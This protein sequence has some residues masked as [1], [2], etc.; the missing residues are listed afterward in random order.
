M[1]P[2]T[3]LR[4]SPPL[5]ML[6]MIGGGWIVLRGTWLLGGGAAAAQFLFPTVS[7]PIGPVPAMQPDYQLSPLF[8]LPRDTMSAPMSRPSARR[9]AA[10]SYA[11]AAHPAGGP[12]AQWAGQ[13]PPVVLA[14]GGGIDQLRRERLLR[15]YLT[16][17]GGRLGLYPLPTHSLAQTGTPGPI[18]LG[19]AGGPVVPTAGDHRWTGSAWGVVRGGGSGRTLAPQLGG[20]QAGARI[21]YRLDARGDVSAFVRVTTAGR[22]GEALEGAAGV[23][24]RPVRGLP[25]TL[26]VERRQAIAGTAGTARSAF[27]AYAVG[28]FADRPVRGDWRADGYGAAGIV[29]GRRHDGFAE[30]SLT[31]MRPAARVR[32]INL[33]IGVGGWGAVQPG[34]SRVDAGPTISARPVRGG[35][36]IAIDWRQRLAGNATPASGPVL[37]IGADF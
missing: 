7:P 33:H 21:S 13:M 17:S 11:G 29:G 19:N 14:M 12:A 2:T 23:A 34:A 36:R 8:W 27:A 1:M 24:I 28:G 22:R 15:D 5:R 30:A 9:S 20:S 3:H 35:P 32:G 37:S 18:D 26:I 10:L 16:S 4:R 25:V 6:L 31:L